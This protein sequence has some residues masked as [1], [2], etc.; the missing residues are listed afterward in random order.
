MTRA[1]YPMTAHK[2]NLGIPVGIPAPRGSRAPA[3]ASATTT[4]PLGRASVGAAKWLVAPLARVRGFQMRH[5]ESTVGAWVLGA[6]ATGLMVWNPGV[7]FGY[8]NSSLHAALDTVGAFLFLLVAFLIS[9]RFARLGRIQDLLVAQGLV[10]LAAAGLGLTVV[11]EAGTDAGI[12][13][14]AGIPATWVALSLRLIGAA[15]MLAGAL[16]GDRPRGRIATPRLIIIVPA[17]VLVVVYVGLWAA[18]S[19]FPTEFGIHSSPALPSPIFSSHPLLVV[20]QLSV[21][22]CFLV[23]SVAFT[24]LS[25]GNTRE[26][27][28]LLGP[29]F[30][31]A[32]FANANYAIL[33]SLS[34]DVLHT[35]DMLRTVSGVLLLVGAA[36]ELRADAG[37]RAASAVLADRRRFARELHDG[38]L[39]EL[40]FIR[41]ESHDLP[42]DSASTIRILGACDRALDE[43]RA[44]VQT[45]GHGD[46]EQLG[47]VLERAAREMAARYGVTIDVDVDASIA[48]NADQRHALLRIT[49]EAV[50]NAVRHGR[51]QHVSIRLAHDCAGRR[52]VIDDDG[53]GFD[54]LSTDSENAGYGLT[55][56]R[57]RAAALPGT[58]AVSTQP[59]TGSAVSVT[60]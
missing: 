33:P 40:A 29:A 31:L 23:A 11:A 34:A 53:D 21:A 41:S 10:L 17:A 14:G 60:W 37:E 1:A 35:G 28:R 12:A 47:V 44:A 43:V 55:S 39:Q 30:A 49:R 50:S 20:G 52:L 5:G 16:V 32:A 22:L 25:A 24:V 56:M 36:R 38:V 46:D 57:E 19:V 58:F 4:P 8:Q 27:A 26:T 3:L 42:P 51:S 9:K 13:A 2:P 18:R 6:A 7:I 54:I 48:S 15:L 59:G 45:L